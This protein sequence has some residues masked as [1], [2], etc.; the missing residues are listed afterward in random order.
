MNNKAFVLLLLI[1]GLLLSTSSYYHTEVR[2]VAITG[3]TI[4]QGQDNLVLSY[5]GTIYRIDQPF[6][7]VGSED[8]IKKTSELFKNNEGVYL[9]STYGWEFKEFRI[10]KKISNAILLLNAGV[11]KPD[12]E[13]NIVPNNIDKKEALEKTLF[14]LGAARK[15]ASE[16]NVEFRRRG[17]LRNDQFRKEICPESQCHTGRSRDIGK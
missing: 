3:P 12:A 16:E 6:F 9:V 10:W 7:A 8:K 4:G 17:R 15:D 5:D 14:W 11:P 1:S 2:P 13:T